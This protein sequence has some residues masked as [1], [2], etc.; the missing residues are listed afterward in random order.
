MQSQIHVCCFHVGML[1]FESYNFPKK[2]LRYVDCSGMFLGGLGRFG[3][4]ACD[5]VGENFGTYLGGFSGCMHSVCSPIT[6]CS[7]ADAS[8]PAFLN[9]QPTCWQHTCFSAEHPTFL[10][11]T[12]ARRKTKRLLLMFFET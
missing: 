7:Q 12:T 1:A 6:I 2:Q 4:Y 11:T 5:I 3:G 8:A 9:P 10:S